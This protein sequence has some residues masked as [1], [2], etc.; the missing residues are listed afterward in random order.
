M[1][2][3]DGPTSS[4]QDSLEPSNV[5]EAVRSNAS[6]VTPIDAISRLRAATLGWGTQDE[7]RTIWAHAEH[8]LA[9]WSL[10]TRDDEIP[11]YQR[12]HSSAM[13]P[14]RVGH[15]DVPHHAASKP[16]QADQMGIAGG[17]KYAVAKK[18]NTPVGAD[19]AD[20]SHATHSSRHWH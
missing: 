1:S 19:V 8:C 10:L 6:I 7:V 12:S 16:V 5:S 18:R 14:R 17:E 20:P 13:T 9:C 3:Q 4:T 2:G 15:V 11:N